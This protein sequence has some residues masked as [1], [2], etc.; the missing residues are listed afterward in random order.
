IGVN[1][2][3]NPNPPDEV[4]PELQ[5][6]TDDEKQSQIKRLREFQGRNEAAAG[7]VLADLKRTATEGGNVFA[8][9]MRAVRVCSLGQITNALFEAGG[10]YR[11]NM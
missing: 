6:S 5:R 1:T 9:L 7:P 10:Q 3:L 8:V 2:F 11:R 4:V